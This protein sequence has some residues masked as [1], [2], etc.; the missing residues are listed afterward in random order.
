MPGLWLSGVL[1][2]LG[3]GWVKV[4]YMMLFRNYKPP[5]KSFA[6]PPVRGVL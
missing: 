4:A 6:S 5:L 2:C 1:L 3:F